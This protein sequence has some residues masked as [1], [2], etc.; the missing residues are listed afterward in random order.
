MDNIEHIT[1]T[2]MGDALRPTC[3]SLRVEGRSY[4]TE[5]LWLV[6]KEGSNLRT[7]H[8]DIR[9]VDKV[10]MVEQLMNEAIAELEEEGFDCYGNKE[11]DIN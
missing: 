1:C 6:Y 8:K 10:R 7:R 5:H 3:S 2:Y 9:T 11:L 4:C